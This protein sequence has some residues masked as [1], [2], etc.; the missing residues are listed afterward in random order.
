MIF[1][2]IATDYRWWFRWHHLFFVQPESFGFRWPSLMQQSMDPCWIWWLFHSLGARCTPILIVLGRVLLGASA[3]HSCSWCQVVHLRHLVICHDL[4][5]TWS[6]QGAFFGEGEVPQVVF[7]QRHLVVFC[8]SCSCPCSCCCSCLFSCILSS[9]ARMDSWI[10]V[11]W[12]FHPGWLFCAE[13]ILLTARIIGNTHI[14]ILMITNFRHQQYYCTPDHQGLS[15]HYG[16]EH[17]GIPM[18]NMANKS[19]SCVPKY[20][21]LR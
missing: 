4:S 6:R 5:A 15:W 18:N 13:I 9:Q 3:F 2:L 21:S 17:I 7:F 14:I 16:R 8:C 1:Y 20:T 10:D 12:S 11:Q 19:P